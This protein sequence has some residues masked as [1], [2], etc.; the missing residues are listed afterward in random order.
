MKKLLYAAAALISFNSH[1]HQPVMDMAPRWEEG[2]GIQ[3]RVT[4]ANQQI[5]T[6]LE[7]VYTF[8]PSLRMTLK[9]PYAGGE[10]GD[11]LFAVPLKRYTNSGAFTSNWGITPSVR[12]PTGGGGDWD[13]GLGISYS[14]ETTSLYQLYDL[15]TMD[16]LVGFDLN[17]G[18]AWKNKGKGFFTLLDIS[19]QKSKTGE[20]VLSGPVLVYFQGGTILRAEFKYPV[21]NEDS[22]WKGNFLS[23]GAG[24]VF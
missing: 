19:A 16:D 18:P 11:A 3:T 9:V 8:K 13:L 14:S 21:H 10:V 2:Y 1:A 24:M 23:L 22:A 5:K 7:G 6:W 4:H 20:R 15:Y 17:V 12:I